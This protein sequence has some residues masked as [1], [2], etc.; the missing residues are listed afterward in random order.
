MLESGTDVRVFR[1]EGLW[2][3][4]GRVE[5]FQSAQ[6]IAWDEQSASIEAVVAA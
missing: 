4:I 6:D 5:D 2:L 1:H 3:D